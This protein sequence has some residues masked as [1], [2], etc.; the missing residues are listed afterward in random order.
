MRW[1]E[2]AERIGARLVREAV[3]HDG[4]CNWVGAVLPEAGERRG[5][6]AALG[7]ELY[8]GSSGIGVF[9]ACLHARTGATGARRTA[10]GALRQ[11]L[12]RIEADPMMLGR[13]LFDG[14]VGIALAAA[15][16]GTVLDEDELLER[17]AKLTRQSACIPG[18]SGFDLLS[19][20][21][22]EA[23]GLLGLRHLLGEEQLLE[24]AADAGEALMRAADRHQ[25]YWSWPQPERSGRPHLTGLSHGAAGAGYALLEL[26]AATGR[27]QY[28]RAAELAFA[29]EQQHYDQRAQNWRD[30]RGWAGRARATFPPT[31]STS[32][33]HGAPGITLSRLRG[34]ALLDD[35]AYRDQAMAGLATTRRAVADG[36]AGASNY[37]LCHG[38]AGNSEILLEGVCQ[39]GTQ[40]T[41]DQALVLETTDAGLA[42]HAVR[43]R[44]WPCGTPADETPGLF[45]GLAGI[46][47]FYL[48]LDHPTIPSVL[49]LRP[50]QFARSS[51]VSPVGQTT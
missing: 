26:S 28:A 22:G 6:V 30:L 31:F 25:L 37:S 49:L 34:Y 50:E 17:A 23:L 5:T 43:R 15:W 19:G 12:S 39:L 9:L 48:R 41:D 35:P 16:A 38:L 11:A 29:Y 18:L 4:R 51:L 27:A 20:S 33:C 32:W 47:L 10:L 2:A 44:A 24:S 13:G 3:W 7:P 14:Q 8:A 21:A 46:G 42:R 36:L 1:S 45:L 40:G